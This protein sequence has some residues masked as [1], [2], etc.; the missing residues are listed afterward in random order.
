MSRHTPCL[1]PPVFNQQAMNPARPNPLLL[2]LPNLNTYCLN[3]VTDFLPFDEVDG[4]KEF[5]PSLMEKLDEES[6]ARYADRKYLSDQC[7]ILAVHVKELGSLRAEMPVEKIRSTLNDISKLYKLDSTNEYAQHL[8]S[9]L[10]DLYRYTRL[11]PELQH[12][13]LRKDFLNLAIEHK[14]APM[15]WGYLGREFAADLK[16]AKYLAKLAN[17]CQSSKFVRCMA[18]TDW[19]YGDET[20]IFDCLLDAAVAL[21]GE[22]VPAIEHLTGA[23]SRLPRDHREERYAR[24]FKL[25]LSEKL[26]VIS[27]LLALLLHVLPEASCKAWFGRLFSHFEGNKDSVGLA[28]LAASIESLPDGEILKAYLRIRDAMP[29]TRLPEFRHAERFVASVPENQRYYAF[30]LLVNDSER[31]RVRLSAAIRALPQE[32]QQ[33]AMKYLFERAE[34]PS[35]WDEVEGSIANLP[36]HLRLEA[37]QFWRKFRG[38]PLEG[39]P[40]GCIQ[41]LPEQN[42]AVEFQKLVSQGCKYPGLT[43]Y[44][45]I[46]SLPEEVREGAWKWALQSHV[47]CVMQGNR[48][49]L[50]PSGGDVLPAWSWDLK[51]DHIGDALLAPHEQGVPALCAAMDRG[52]ADA[53]AAYGNLLKYPRLDSGMRRQLLELP[54]TVP[55]ALGNAMKRGDKAVIKAYAKLVVD[56]QGRNR[57]DQRD[58]SALLQKIRSVQG[59]RPVWAVG[60]WVNNSDY[61]NVV[62]KDPV[63]KKA[64]KDAKASL[65]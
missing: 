58:A 42:R 26:T 53:I 50:I 40:F 65:K 46:K 27:Y 9:L 48:W 6:N 13:E 52:D 32:S 5:H 29:S 10:G 24:I 54:L 49:N 22:G 23:L 39:S 64:F 33:N 25:S 21:K 61:N 41:H 4:L 60:V 11:L 2:R 17:D 44:N 19:Q 14:A 31:I 3:N 55:S 20:E 59:S 15:R 28:D 12:S 18:E 47:A 43:I 56:V 45:V 30:T 35:D 36:E 7:K 37:F 62:L 63:L 16:T 51:L 1:L 34:V 8:E 38:Q 57:L